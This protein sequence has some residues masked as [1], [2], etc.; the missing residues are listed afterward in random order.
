MKKTIQVS[1]SLDYLDYYKEDKLKDK[2][3]VVVDILRATSCMVAGLG[4][5][6][7][8]IQT[9]TEVSEALEYKKQG[10]ICAGERGGVKLPEFDLGNSPFEFM[11]LAGKKVV[12]TTTNGTK[13]IALAK[14]FSNDV[15]NI[16]IGAFLNLSALVNILCRRKKNVIVLCSGWKGHF[17][18]EDTLF[19]GALT[20]HLSET[21]IMQGDEAWAAN[22]LYQYSKS[23]LK[24][25]LLQ[26]EHAK[27]LGEKK[28]KDIYFCGQKS[29]FEIAPVVRCDGSIRL[30]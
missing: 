23:N 7:S 28:I 11:N 24:S 27:R 2:T 17:S 6:I 9:V 4:T 18:L 16:Y 1:L 20:Y 12:M 13:A 14:S 5:G 21:H 19:A 30:E 3:I 10:Y 15:N 29:V 8:K 26:T 25:A 22:A